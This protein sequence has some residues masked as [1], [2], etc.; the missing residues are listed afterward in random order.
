MIFRPKYITFDC[1][2]TLTYFRMHEV[3]HGIVGEQLPAERMQ[4][5]I[6]D[7]AAYRLDEVMGDWK[8]Y[9]HPL[10]GEVEIGGFA[11]DV[12]RVPPSFL[13]EELVH[14]NALF[15]L[16]HAEA[17]PRVVIKEPL[18]TDLGGGLRALDVIIENEHVIP[19]RTALARDKKIGQPD[20]ILLEGEGVEVLAGGIR[21]DRFR[22]ERMELAEREPAR[23]VR[24]AGL[25]PR[26]ELRVRWIVRG[27]GTAKVTYRGEKARAV[28]RA[29]EVR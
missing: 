23:L 2:G 11:K 16:R 5:F 13:V 28:E 18:V 21:T 7:F 19:T 9:D 12:G 29:V 4:Q 27:E 26:E 22:P 10:F 6:K 1:Y 25:G 8:P 17:L 24:E 3:A 15:C 20:L 14:R